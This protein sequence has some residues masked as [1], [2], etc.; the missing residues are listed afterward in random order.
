MHDWLLRERETLSR[1][2]EVPKPMNCMLRRW[3][4]FARFLDDGRICLTTDGV[5][6]SLPSVRS[7]FFGFSFQAATMRS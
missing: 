5:E 3:E 4:G 6:K 7:N 1:S 2:S